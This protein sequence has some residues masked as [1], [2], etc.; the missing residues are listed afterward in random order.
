MTWIAGET[1]MLHCKHCGELICR[2]FATDLDDLWM[3]HY[4]ACEAFAATLAAEDA[5][6]RDDFT[7]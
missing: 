2:L 1:P 7:S 4:K 6:Y 3:Q 5:Y